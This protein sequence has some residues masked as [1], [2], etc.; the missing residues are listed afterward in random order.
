MFCSPAEMLQPHAAARPALWI[1]SPEIKPSFSNVPE[2][3]HYPC[4]NQ[5]YPHAEAIVI[6]TNFPKVFYGDSKKEPGCWAAHLSQP[7]PLQVY[8]MNHKL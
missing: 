1:S 4:L 7:S 3:F 8:G 2:D 6:V 5:L